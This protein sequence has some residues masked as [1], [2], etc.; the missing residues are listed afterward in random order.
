MK[1]LILI[2]LLICVSLLAKAQGPPF[3]ADVD[4][5]GYT[6]CHDSLYY[7]F[8]ISA[9]T[10]ATGPTGV[11][12]VTGIVVLTLAND[13]G[14]AIWATL[15]SLYGPTG[16]TGNTGVTGSTGPT[17]SQGAT[18]SQGI[19][20]P[21]GSTGATGVTGITGVTGATG[22]TGI[23]GVT[24]VTG[25]TGATGATGVTGNNGSTGATGSTGTNGSTGA[26]GATGATGS[27]GI[28]GSTGTTGSTGATG[29]TGPTGATGS[30]GA[31]GA[32]GGQTAY[33]CSLYN[34]VAQTVTASTT[35]VLNFDSEWWDNTGYHSNVTNNSR[36]TI[37]SGYNGKYTLSANI[38]FVNPTVGTTAAFISFLKNG[39]T[40]VTQENFLLIAGSIITVSVSGI[41]LNVSDYVQ[42]EINFNGTSIG[43]GVPVT[44]YELH[45]FNAKFDGN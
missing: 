42:C 38:Y 35:T 23:T 31:T 29:A 28:T 26:T 39:T 36:I 5:Y 32:T 16:A 45:M 4:I 21:T 43:A 18:G 14:Y 10:G 2:K 17:G 33:G 20:G 40:T 11:S 19:T 34:S 9:I 7:P 6:N 24:G 41:V 22:M 3:Y 37:P 30:T 8:G 13:S 15:P 1:K 25:A 27:M 44:G 12:G